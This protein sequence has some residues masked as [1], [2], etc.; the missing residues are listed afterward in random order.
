MGCTFIGSLKDLES[1]RK[2]ELQLIKHAHTDPITNFLILVIPEAIFQGRAFTFDMV[3]ALD[4]L[5]NISPGFLYNRK[6]LFVAA[7]KQL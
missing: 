2:P 3:G 4:R 7:T 5:I 6:I 1:F